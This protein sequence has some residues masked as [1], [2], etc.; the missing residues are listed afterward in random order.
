[1][2]NIKRGLSIAIVAAMVLGMTA[3]GGSGT[4]DTKGGRFTGGR[5]IRG[6]GCIRDGSGDGGCL[7]GQSGENERTQAILELYSQQNPG[8]TFDG[9]FQ[10]GQIT[11]TSWLRPLPVIPCRI[12]SRWITSISSSM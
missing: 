12:S 11:G 1:M 5:S 6:K 7:V 2:K 4:A 3:C 8:V 10:S 9:Q